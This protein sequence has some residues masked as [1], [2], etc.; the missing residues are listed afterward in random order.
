MEGG[1]EQ[2]KTRG[3]AS[4]IRKLL[5]STQ[6]ISA[7]IKSVAMGEK[8][9]SRSIKEIGLRQHDDGLQIAFTGE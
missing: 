5:S 4:S 3:K 1:L 2:N 6:S 8:R 9:N 7:W